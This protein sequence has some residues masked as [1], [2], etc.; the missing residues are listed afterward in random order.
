[1]LENLVAWI[2][3]NYIGEYFSLN[4]DQLSVAFLQGFLKKLNLVIERYKSVV[5]LL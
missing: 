5:G 4:T 3:N 1:M 2:L